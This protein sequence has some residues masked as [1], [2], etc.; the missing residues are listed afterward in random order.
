MNESFRIKLEGRLADYRSGSTGRELSGCRWVQYIGVKMV[1]AVDVALDTV[2][3][4][5][6]NAISEGFRVDWAE[7]WG[8][9]YIRVWEGRLEPTWDAVFA[10]E[11]AK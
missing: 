9:L 11:D 1:G 6:T 8:R 4:G 7:M 5:L 2:E 10:E 3:R